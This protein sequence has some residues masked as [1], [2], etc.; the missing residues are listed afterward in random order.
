MSYYWNTKGE[1]RRR[2]V[3]K[4]TAKQLLKACGVISIKK[5]EERWQEPRYGRPKEYF[6]EVRLP[7]KVVRARAW[8]GGTWSFSKARGRGNPKLNAY[9]R[10]CL[11]QA[12]KKKFYR[13]RRRYY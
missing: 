4:R 6:Y 8:G 7:G 2:K 12:L 13:P 1:Y 3:P 10:M 5:T 11:A 9:E